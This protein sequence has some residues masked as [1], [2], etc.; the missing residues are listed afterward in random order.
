MNK[1]KDIF[2]KTDYIQNT[3]KIFQTT[4]RLKLSVF[5]ILKKIE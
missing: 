4:K 1:A 5:E 2:F 3:L